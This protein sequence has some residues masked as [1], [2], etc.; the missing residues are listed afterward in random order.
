MRKKDDYYITFLKYAREIMGEGTVDYPAV[1]EHVHSIHP[2][3]SEEAFKRTF[4]QAVVTIGYLGRPAL[5]EDIGRGRLSE[6]LLSETT[7]GRA[8]VTRI[9][10]NA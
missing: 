3:V 5:E 4:L 6:R 1:F 7:R 10:C 2:K 9:P 8:M